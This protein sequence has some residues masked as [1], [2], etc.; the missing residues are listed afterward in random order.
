[1]TKPWLFCIFLFTTGIAV[2]QPYPFNGYTLYDYLVT[3]THP[4]GCP[5]TYVTGLPEDSTWVNMSDFSVMP[6]YFGFPWKDLPGEDLLLESSFHLDNYSVKLI[7]EGRTLSSAFMVSQPMWTIYPNVDWDH[8]FTGCLPG[9]AA[10]P[11]NMID[12]DFGVFGIGPDDV[13]VGIEITFLPTSGQADFA[14]AYIIVPPCELLDLGPDTTICPG[15]TITIDATMPNANATY[16]WQDGSTNA[17][18]QNAGPGTYTVQVTIYDCS[19]VRTI[20]VYEHAGP[21]SLGNDTVL[22]SGETLLLDVT[23]DDATYVWQNNSTQSTF[24]VTQAG[25][26]SVTVTIDDCTYIDNIEVAFANP[27]VI[28]LGEDVTICEGVTLTLDAT[29]SNATYEWQDQFTGSTYVVT[30]PGTYSVIVD[31]GGCASEDEINVDY[32]YPDPVD[33]GTDITLCTGESIFL[34]AYMDDATYTWQDNSQASGYLVNTPGNYSVTVTTDGCSASDEIEVNYIP[35]IQ[36]N[37]GNDTILCNGESLLLNAATPN[38]TYTWQ[39]NTTSPTYNVTTSG[40]YYVTVQVDL[41]ETSDTI[42]VTIGDQLAIDLGRDT[43]L[44]EGETLLLDLHSK[45]GISY[46]WQDLSTADTFLVSSP[47]QYWVEVT[48]NECTFSDTINIQYINLGAVNL[49]NDTT[50]CNTETLLLDAQSSDLTYTWQ[51]NSTNPT[52][53]VT[54]PGTYWVVV[55]QQACSASDTV[56]VNYNIIVPI[57]LGNDTTLCAGATLFLDAGLTNATFMWQ[58]QSTS[59]TFTVALPGTYWVSAQNG[60]CSVTDSIVVNYLSLLSLNL[61]SDTSLCMDQALILDATLPGASYLWQDN[62]TSSTYNVTQPGLFWVDVN[63]G[64]CMVSDSILIDY[65]VLTTPD[66]GNDTLLCKGQTL[67]LDAGSSGVTYQW[68]DNSTNPDFLV[69]QSGTYSV[70]LS[71]GA[72]DVADTIEVGYHPL[73]NVDLGNDTTLCEGQT[74][75]LNAFST[76]LSY[77]WQDQSTGPEYLVTMP[78]DYF[79]NVSDGICENTDTIHVAY[80]SISSINLGNDTLLCPDQLLLLQPNAPGAQ[81][82]WHDNSTN[83]IFI[84]TEPGEYWVHVSIGACVAGDTIQVEIADPIAVDLGM[85]TMLCPGSTLLLQGTIT[86]ATYEWHDQ[87]L[88]PTYLVSQPGIYWVIANVMGCKASDTISVAYTT[89]PELSIGNDTVLCDGDML[90]LDATTQNAIYTWQDQSTDPTYLVNEPGTYAVHVT[91]DACIVVDTIQIDYLLPVAFSLGADRMICDGETVLLDP[92]ISEDVEYLWQDQS[93]TETYVV[94][95]AGLYWLEAK[96]A[97]GITSDTV[98]V[99]VDQCDCRLFFPNV[100]SPNGDN[101]NDQAFPVSTCALTTYQL[102]IFDRYGGLLFETQEIGQ[103]WDG[104]SKS[105]IAQ[106]GVYV[107][108]ITYAFEAGKQQTITGDVTVLR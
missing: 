80:L 52:F 7:L 15:E 102:K 19:V 64:D 1:M 67:L 36:I 23:T 69:T 33:L 62:S 47:G 89:L 88:L 9:Q 38:A 86:N 58:D 3:A 76:G 101:I 11:R 94:N 92:G 17:I 22:C 79:V 42:Q 60:V 105:K 51:D 43:I 5:S 37:L 14:G 20:H 74:I 12:L 85:D 4:N 95:D 82:D 93:T 78:G 90:V 97:C 61:G 29:T 27:P 21:L 48:V 53:T 18:Y 107:Y 34:D 104:S 106:S 24:N 6:A 84:V 39:D 103:G 87:S 71:I 99:I 98:S 83:P 63:I 56:Q 46:Q 72:C 55:S 35:A 57:A 10:S 26:Y 96:G 31:V 8:M 59:S 77:E 30:E 44:C 45:N 81:F 54:Q 2:A 16:L 28:N 40:S 70:T 50:L 108:L 68:Q 25:S 32:I 75:L 73:I 65:V 41:C 49:G 13:V 91:I 100:L 66:L